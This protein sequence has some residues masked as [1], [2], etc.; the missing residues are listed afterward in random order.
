MPILGEIRKGIEQPP[1]VRNWR[2]LHICGWFGSYLKDIQSD[3]PHEAR[4]QTWP[5]RSHYH[6]VKWYQIK[7]RG[8]P[9]YLNAYHRP[10]IQKKSFNQKPEARNSDNGEIMGEGWNSHMWSEIDRNCIF[11]DG[12]G[13]I[14]K[15]F[16]QNS[17]MRPE[18]KLD[19]R[20]HMT[21][22]S[23]W[24]SLA[25]GLMWEVW[26]NIFQIVPKPSANM[27]FPSISDHRWLFQPSL[28][29]SPLSLFLASGL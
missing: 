20:G 8:H 26:L 15:I 6:S 28:I 5:W 4:G 2:E 27:R 21:T 24:S 22:Q 19:L 17:H 12:L 9:N 14:W 29:I 1:V 3:L 25:S 13:A 18:A 16:N 11:V 10:K 7:S 23:K